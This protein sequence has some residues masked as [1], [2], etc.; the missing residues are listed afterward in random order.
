MFVFCGSNLVQPVIFGSASN[1]RFRPAF[2]N[3]SSAQ[4]AIESTLFHTRW[5]FTASLTADAPRGRSC[6]GVWSNERGPRRQLSVR[7]IAARAIKAPT[8]CPR[9]EMS[10]RGVAWCVM[11]WSLRAACYTLC[12]VRVV[13][14]GVTRSGVCACVMW[15]FV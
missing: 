12:V 5:E 8:R 4:V 6:Y 14:Y 3:F 9:G 15:C 13:W 11:R 10:W 2:L 7:Q 1:S